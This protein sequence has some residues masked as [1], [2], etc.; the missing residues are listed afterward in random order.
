MLLQPPICFNNLVGIGSSGEDLRHQGIWIQR[1]RRYQLLQL[2]R[3]LWRVLNR[4]LC[5]GLVSLRHQYSRRRDEQK[6]TGKKKR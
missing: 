1:D 3:R 4:R 5:G 2:F 6:T